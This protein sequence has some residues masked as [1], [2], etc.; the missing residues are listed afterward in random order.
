MLVAASGAVAAALFVGLIGATAGRMA[1][2]DVLDWILQYG[3][4]PRDW[5]AYLWAPH[6]EHRIAADRLLIAIDIGWFGG[7]GLPF[8][9]VRTALWLGMTAGLMR[10]VARMPL[11]PGARIALIAGLAFA[12]LP[13][14]LVVLC[15]MPLMGGFIHSCACT[16]FALLLWD[17]HNRWRQ[18]AALAS[19][20][21]AGLGVAGGLFAWPV[22]L[23]AIWRGGGS[24]RLLLTVCVIGLIVCGV[25]LHGLPAH[26]RSQS[27]SPARL[28]AS[29]DFVLRF[30]GLPWSHAPSLL[31]FGRAAGAALFVLASGM[32]IADAWTRRPRPRAERM[33]IALLL[34]ALITALAAAASRWNVAADREMPI[35]YAVIA[36]LAHAGLLLAGASRIARVIDGRYA[37]RVHAG[38]VAAAAVL[39]LQQ[40]LVGRAALAQ[41][42]LYEDA[43]AQFTAGMWS[44]EMPHYV[45]PDRARA[46]QALALMRA[47]HLYGQ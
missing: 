36:A 19:A 3:D 2:Y 22:L 26:A 13:S 38:M 30:L 24:A 42:R 47:R 14:S 16:V 39:L 32:V 40:V 10:Q 17:N 34:F 15:S 25:Y 43:W 9:V 45:H 31:W 27:F 44:A 21:V 5:I 1:G 33:G 4:G 12:L 7:T 35:R 29:I 41:V 23:F 11:A 37:P 20:A 8:T 6:N 18:G 28:I 46:E